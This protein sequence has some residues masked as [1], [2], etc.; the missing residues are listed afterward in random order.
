MRRSFTVIRIK[1]WQH[2]IRTGRRIIFIQCSYYQYV[3][4]SFGLSLFFIAFGFYIYK[5]FCG[6]SS[7]KKRKMVNIA[8][9]SKRIKMNEKNKL[10]GASK[11][12]HSRRRLSKRACKSASASGDVAPLP[13]FPPEPPATPIAWGFFTPVAIDNDPDA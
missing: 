4:Y 11:V 6:N 5:Y 2:L 8:I 7:Y 13:P 9:Y 3:L 12:I 10:F 1:R